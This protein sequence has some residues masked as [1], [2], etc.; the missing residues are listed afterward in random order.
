MAIICPR[1]DLCHEDGVILCEKSE[2]IHQ[3]F[4]REVE[5]HKMYCKGCPDPEAH[6]RNLKAQ[7]RKAP[8]IFG[9]VGTVL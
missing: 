2:E 6:V 4:R 3:T 8:I 5:H 7:G 9:E 1:C